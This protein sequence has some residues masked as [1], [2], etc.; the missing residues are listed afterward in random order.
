MHL[1][2]TENGISCLF[3]LFFNM[4]RILYVCVRNDL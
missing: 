4:L 1:R 3:Y 2:I